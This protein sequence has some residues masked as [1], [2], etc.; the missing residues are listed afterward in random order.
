MD[1]FSYR[2]LRVYQGALLLVTS[3]YN[4]VK[5]FP[6]EDRYAL[7]DQLR[8]AIVSVPSNL[9]EGLSRYSRKEQL[10]FMELSYGSLMEVMC[11]IEI[12]KSLGYIN[13]EL[14]YSIE[15]DIIVIAKQLSGLRKSLQAS[16]NKKE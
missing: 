2:N 6:I 14:F 1:I 8:R 11:Q 13:E 10:H 12:S 5:C 15:S 16:L 4:V 3:I 7:S 9:A